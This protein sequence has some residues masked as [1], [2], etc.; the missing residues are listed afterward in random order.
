MKACTM[1]GS[2]VA[3]RSLLW[4]GLYP[5]REEAGE[6]AAASSCSGNPCNPLLLRAKMAVLQHVPGCWLSCSPASPAPAC[7]CLE[8]CSPASP[9]SSC[10]MSLCPW[11]CLGET[12]LM[13]HPQQLLQVVLGRTLSDNTFGVGHCSHKRHPRNVG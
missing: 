7:W 1:G 10:P 13:E 12:P 5:W 3:L 4:R 6:E 2:F 9:A 8:M 11:L